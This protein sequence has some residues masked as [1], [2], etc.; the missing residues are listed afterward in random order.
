[1]SSELMTTVNAEATAPVTTGKP[2]KVELTPEQKAQRKADAIAKAEARK[3]S[4][5][6]AQKAQVV[7]AN[8]ANL[9][10]TQS[11]NV[12]TLVHRSDNSKQWVA[13]NWSEIKNVAQL[14]YSLDVAGVAID[15]A[16]AQ[17]TQ[18]ER[19]IHVM[20]RKTVNVTENKRN[21]D[22]G[23][24]SAVTTAK[25]RYM[26]LSVTSHFELIPA[27]GFAGEDGETKQACEAWLALKGILEVVPMDKLAL[28]FRQ[29]KQT[30]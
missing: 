25:K 20:L 10:I 16:F 2:A 30:A 14:M 15:S 26:L 18:N 6:K 21:K 1:M 7:A 5:D 8:N 3:A 17:V 27:F 24:Y 9:A 28:H 4:S 23:A 22:T 19:V 13:K 29:P 11:R 12:S